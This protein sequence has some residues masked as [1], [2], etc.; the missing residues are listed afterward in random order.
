MTPSD[1]VEKLLRHEQPPSQ[2]VKSQLSLYGCGH[3]TY[4][5][6]NGLLPVTH[7]PTGAEN[8]VPPQ[9]APV[10][11][12]TMIG[13]SLPRSNIICSARESSSSRACGTLT[14]ATCS[15]AYGRIADDGSSCS[16]P[17]QR[18]AYVAIA[19]DRISERCCCGIAAGPRVLHA[20]CDVVSTL[21]LFEGCG[22][23]RPESCQEGDRQSGNGG[24]HA[25]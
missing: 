21:T 8:A 2:D 18:L 20:N 17:V 14:R 23:G 11:S 24:K 15:N 5:L 19:E 9:F 1:Q 16:E 12:V 10:Y 4:V 6:T 13:I 7:P 22:D 25:G 3:V